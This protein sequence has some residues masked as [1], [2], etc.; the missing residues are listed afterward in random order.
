MNRLVKGD[1]V[2]LISGKFKSKEGVILS[3]DRKSNTAIVEGVN[4][5][6]RHEK[7]SQK[8]N[9][10]GGVTTKEAPIALN[11][12]ALIVDKAKNGISK[13]TFKINKEG[14]KVRVSKKTKAELKGTSKK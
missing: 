5:V 13:V 9:N 4:K 10:K 8:N 7:P 1:K 2:R 14:K 6:K 12:L 3:I 11:K